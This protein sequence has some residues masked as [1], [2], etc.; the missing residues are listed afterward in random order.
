MNLHE[1]NDPEEAKL[2][3]IVDI[4]LS[5]SAMMR[6]FVKGTSKT[7]QSKVLTEVRRLF[8]AESEE[9]YRSIHSSLCVWGTKNIIT[10]ERRKNGQIIK[11]SGPA[12]YGQ[13]AKTL[14]VALKVVFYY[15]HLPDCER[16]QLI[17]KW[18]NAAVDT[19][20]MAMLKGFHPDDTKSWPTSLE[21]VDRS[22]YAM[23]Q[24]NVHKF[25]NERHG[26]RIIPVQF[27]DMYWEALNR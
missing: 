12:S 1:T 16:S 26:G 8:E 27:D 13:I 20:M 3:I 15:C 10:A 23:I 22:A 18:L 17:S 21:Q 5:S 11:R 19:K 25:I 4:G 24:E 2:H 7:L 9:Q 6:N 14:D